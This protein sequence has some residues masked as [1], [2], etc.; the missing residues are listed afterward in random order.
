M[1]ADRLITISVG[2]IKDS[3][4][5]WNIVPSTF[6]LYGTIRAVLQEDIATIQE[7]IRVLA[8]NT[9]KSYGL[10]SDVR[11]FQDVP[12]L[13]NSPSWV[14]EF[15]PSVENVVGKNNI[16]YLAPQLGY[17]DISCFINELGGAYFLLGGQ[18]TEFLGDGFETLH[19][20]EGG[21]GIGF[22]H[23]PY[24]YFNDEAMKVG[25]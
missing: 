16:K 24:F 5:R 13:T 1:P 25:V 20:I 9:C 6:T 15:M 17:D 23:N 7:K 12:A 4:G 14:A 21:K 18:D 8:M 10:D 11:F 3:G 2:Q 22:N 19:P